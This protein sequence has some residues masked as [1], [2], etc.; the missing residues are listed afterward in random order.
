MMQMQQNKGE[1]PLCPANLPRL[2]LRLKKCHMAGDPFGAITPSEVREGWRAHVASL[3]NPLCC[4]V[5]ITNT[6]DPA[7]RAAEETQ[8]IRREPSTGGEADS[9]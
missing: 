1:A 6:A 5:T 7:A 4:Q 3:F 2:S 8:S 9:L